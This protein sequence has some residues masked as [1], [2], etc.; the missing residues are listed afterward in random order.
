MSEQL[1]L[2]LLVFS[3]LPSLIDTPTLTVNALP[4]TDIDV[5]IAYQMVTNGTYPNLVILDVRTKTEFDTGH[6]QK[7]LLIPHTEL[8]QRIDELEEHK[9]HEIIVY[10]QKGSRSRIACGTLDAHE[11]IRIYNMMGGIEAWIGKDY[12]VT[13]SY[14]TEILFN[15]TPNPATAGQTIV[16]KGILIDQFSSP[17]ANET[18]KLHYRTR[19]S[20]WH[21]AKTL[22]TNAY[23]TF[24][25]NGK[26]QKFGIYQLCVSYAGWTV[27]EPSYNFAVLIVQP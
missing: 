11:F 12:P 13:T 9:N 4:Y 7:A 27:Y 14:S 16:L 3:T 1:L 8:E 5:D 10:C 20:E 22:T 24:V 6:L 21:F 25:A 18:V 15:I 2:I 17:I 19:F 26:P 23:G